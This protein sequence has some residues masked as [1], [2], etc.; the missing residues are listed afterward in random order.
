MLLSLLDMWRLPRIALQMPS[1]ARYASIFESRKA[2]VARERK[3]VKYR[4]RVNA[5][6][7]DPN[8]PSEEENL[9]P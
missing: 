8:L 6:E 5:P 4:K 7:S 1:N 3:S 2:K 9:F